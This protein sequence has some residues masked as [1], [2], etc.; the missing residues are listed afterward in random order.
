VPSSRSKMVYDAGMLDITGCEDVQ[1]QVT[2][3]HDGNL[4]LHVNTKDGCVLRIC[5]ITG[6]V[7][8]DVDNPTKMEY[9]DV[10]S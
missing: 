7:D 10:S 9:I 1:I 5:K 3:S 4:V 2:E 6:E 8:V